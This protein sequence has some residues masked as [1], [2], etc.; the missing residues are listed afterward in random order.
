LKVLVPGH[1]GYFSESKEGKLKLIN[2][3]DFDLEGIKIL[4]EHFDNEGNSV[5][6]SNDYVSGI[7]RK[8]GYREFS[9]YTP[10]CSKCEKQ[11]FSINLLEKIIKNKN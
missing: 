5:N 7:I 9:W 11:E 10:E 8:H 3:S 6:T 4:I 2:N 1:R